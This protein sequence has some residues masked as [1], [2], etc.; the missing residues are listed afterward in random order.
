MTHESE[1]PILSTTLRGKGFSLRTVSQDHLAHL[2]K[3]DSDITSLYLWT[4][5]RNPLSEIG[6]REFVASR[7]KEGHFLIIHRDEI[8]VGFIYSYDLNLTDGFLFIT[9]FMDPSSRG[10][11]FGAKAGILFADYLFAYYPM[12][13]IYCDVFDYNHESLSAIRKAGFEV[14][15]AFKEHRFYGGTYHTL[16][17]FALY[18]E[19]F[20]K[21]FRNL[22]PRIR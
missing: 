5:R 12:R 16:Y 4:G 13:K 6:Y 9:I 7:A 8:P 17:R 15:G 2:H 21:R 22:L 1:N 18:R 3:W 10:K 20:Y 11:G 19:V 14:E